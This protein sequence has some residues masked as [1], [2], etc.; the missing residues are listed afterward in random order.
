[1][2]TMMRA[3]MMM[4]MMKKK[5]KMTMM[6]HLSVVR[7]E[8][9]HRVDIARS[10][11]GLDDPDCDVSLLGIRIRAAAGGTVLLRAAACGLLPLALDQGNWNTGTRAGGEEGMRRVREVVGRLP[12]SPGR[13]TRPRDKSPGHSLDGHGTPAGG[14]LSEEGTPLWTFPP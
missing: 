2:N 3:G 13:H 8:D 14:G 10:Q 6:A 11:E 1:M 7:R 5:A 4:M 9:S 12:P